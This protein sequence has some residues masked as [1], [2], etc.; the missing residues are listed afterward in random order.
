MP[1]IKIDTT[2]IFDKWLDKL[3]DKKA[4]MIIGLHIERIEEDNLGVI[5]SVGQGVFEKKINY[6]PG[7]RLYFCQNGEAWILLLCGGN[8]STQKTDIKKAH[9]IKKGLQ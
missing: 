8:K 5:R 6:G 3:K 9:L 4:K 1:Q 2:S 7:Y